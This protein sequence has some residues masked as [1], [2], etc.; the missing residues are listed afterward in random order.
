[1][2]A[3]RNATPTHSPKNG[4]NHQRLSFAKNSDTLEV[5]NLLEL[6]LERFDRQVG[7][8]AWK[9]RVVE[10]QQAGRDKGGVD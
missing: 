9:T 3:A 8:D 5:P 4:R 2:A 10:A 6:Q 1:M 7:S